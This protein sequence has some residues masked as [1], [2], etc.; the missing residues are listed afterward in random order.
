ME[1]GVQVSKVNNA[2]LMRCPVIMT[3][4]SRIVLYTLYTFSNSVHSS[5]YTVVYTFPLI[6]LRSTPLLNSAIFMYVLV[7][8]VKILFSLYCSIGHTISLLDSHSYHI[9]FAYSLSIDPSN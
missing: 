7:S 4:R 2:N 8:L 1:V 5:Q 9:R 6:S 3:S